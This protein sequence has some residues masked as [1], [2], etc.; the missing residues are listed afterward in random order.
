MTDSII[1]D[2][3]DSETLKKLE[4][5][6]QRRGVDVNSL[7]SQLLKELLKT[8][9]GQPE[10]LNGHEL[11]TLAGTWSDEEAKAFLSNMSDFE[12]IDTDLWK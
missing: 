4:D 7:A 3:L 10:H 5:E 8:K 12:I 1:I 11:D 6:A 9:A 2:S